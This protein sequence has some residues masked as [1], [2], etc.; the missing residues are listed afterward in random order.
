MA[1]YD[2][3]IGSGKAIVSNWAGRRPDSDS[4]VGPGGRGTQ[5]RVD[6]IRHIS[7]EGSLSI[8]DLETGKTKEIV[9][10]L[11]ASAL[12]ISPDQHYCVC[13]NAGSDHLSIIDLEK[14]EWIENVSTKLKANDIFG[15]LSKRSRVPA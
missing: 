1:P 5:V 8:I 3:V 12:A 6:P 10:G 2:V 15:A 14:E 13:A 11:H 9:T 4:V 7:S